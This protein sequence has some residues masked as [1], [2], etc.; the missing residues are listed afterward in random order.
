MCK[1]ELKQR[2]IIQ[3]VISRDLEIFGGLT[4]ISFGYYFVFTK[5]MCEEV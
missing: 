4:Q 5:G 1:E 2:I 3:R